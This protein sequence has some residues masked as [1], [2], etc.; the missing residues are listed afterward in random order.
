MKQVPA[1]VLEMAKD[2]WNRE[3]EGLARRAYETDWAAVRATWGD[4]VVSAWGSVRSRVKE[5]GENK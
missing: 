2:K 3:I 5:V 4:R 1:G